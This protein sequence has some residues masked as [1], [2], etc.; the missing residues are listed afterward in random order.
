MRISLTPAKGEKFVFS[1]LPETVR[2]RYGVKSQSFD[3][4]S[5]GTIKVPKGTEVPEVSWEGEFF[6]GSR[7]N[8]AGVDTDNWKEPNSCVKILRNWMNDKTELTLIISGTWINMD[9]K[10]VS[11]ES[12]A[13]GGY[14]DISYSIV[15]ERIRD[16]K[17]Y[18]TKESDVGKKKKTKPRAKKKSGNTDSGGGAGTYTV[19]SG[20][21]LCRIA[22]KKSTTW[23]KLYSKNKAVIESAAKKHG[24]K[25]SDHGHWIWPGTKLTIP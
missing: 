14:G 9:V 5:K 12:K 18:N 20:D 22:R 13:H 10:I 19:R 23:Q 16:L 17:I 15:F 25:S 3:I 8:L 24:R 2:A 1:L 6:G 21:T 7:K 11:F 4:I